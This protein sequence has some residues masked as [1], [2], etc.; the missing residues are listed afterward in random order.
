MANTTLMDLSTSFSKMLQK[1]S[2]DIL[3]APVKRQFPPTGQIIN[4]NHT[5]DIVIKGRENPHLHT[6]EGIK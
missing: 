4:I 3:E 6:V 5:R 1:R 2:D